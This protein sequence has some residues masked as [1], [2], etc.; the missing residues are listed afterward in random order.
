MALAGSANLILHIPAIGTEAGYDEPWWKFFDD[1]SNEI[2]LLAHIAPSG[3]YSVKDLD[4]AGGLPAVLKELMPKLNGDCPT[5]TG[6]TLKE[7]AANAKVYRREVI[8][9]LDAPVTSE[10]GVGVLYGNIAPEGAIL[11]IAGVPKQL[12][13]FRGPAN[14]FDSLDEARD[15]L[16]AG[17]IKPGDACVLRFMGL[18]ARFGTTAFPFQDELKGYKAL[19]ESCAIITDGRYSGASAGLSVGY[20]SP[21][22]ALGS[23]LAIIENGDTIEIDVAARQMNVLLSDEEIKARL[24][25]FE[26]V[27]PAADYPPMLRLFS[28]NVGS[29]A[30]GGAWKF[31]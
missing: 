19:F 7:N 2:P 9:T 17:K 20:C 4:L 16:R 21:E 27:F 15:A 12:M 26:F 29:M 6:K 3:P 31:I 25:K 5:V 1:A 10:P 18:K 14:V 13:K 28:L 11:K 24:D 8:H 30:K 22:A 23:A